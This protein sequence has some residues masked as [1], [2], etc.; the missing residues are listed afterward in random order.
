MFYEENPPTRT[1]K[2]AGSGGGVCVLEFNFS[3]TRDEDVAVKL[4]LLKGLTNHG[5][6]NQNSVVM[7]LLLDSYDWYMVLYRKVV[8][9]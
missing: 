1:Q 2:Q 7:L 6:L 5:V 9:H 3:D 8:K 4:S